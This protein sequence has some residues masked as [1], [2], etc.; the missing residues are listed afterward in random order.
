MLVTVNEN[1]KL[2]CEL[3]TV[4]E[5]FNKQHNHLIRDIKH[6]IKQLPSLTSEFIETTYTDNRNRTQKT[7]QLTQKGFSLLVFGFNGRKALEYKCKFYDEFERMRRENNMLRGILTELLESK[8]S[9]TKCNEP[10]LG[11]ITKSNNLL[12]T[13]E[14]VERI[15]EIRRENNMHNTYL[16]LLNRNYDNTVCITDICCKFKNLHPI[17]ANKELQRIGMIEQRASG[18]YPCTEYLG[19]DTMIS[20]T[21]VNQYLNKL[22]NYV[23]YTVKGYDLIYNKFIE[24]GYEQV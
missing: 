1:N 19:S 10:N 13:N 4:S 22:E 20:A 5:Y 8:D 24:L 6:L 7:Y 18:Y 12:S 23:R 9:I 16:S 2:V 21:A 14:I 15:K 3:M 11:L 17:D